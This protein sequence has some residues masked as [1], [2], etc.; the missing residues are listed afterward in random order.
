MPWYAAECLYYAD[1]S[2]KASEQLGEYRYFLLEAPDDEAAKMKA[3]QLART[4]E[5]SY[6]GADGTQV[7]WLLESVTDVKEI[8]DDKLSEGTELYHK[9]FDRYVTEAVEK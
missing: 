1:T 8:L 3:W 2:P 4:R 7:M 5:H 6:T 9:Y